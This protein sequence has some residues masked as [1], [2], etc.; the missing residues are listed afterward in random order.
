[1]LRVVRRVGIAIGSIVAA[2]LVIS[3]VG[4]VL[5]PFV[6]VPFRSTDPGA[7]A[8]SSAIVGLITLIL[9]GLIYRDIIRRERRP[10]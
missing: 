9:G 2:W 5:L 7:T 4:A 10:S 1:M 3:L 6:G 8:S